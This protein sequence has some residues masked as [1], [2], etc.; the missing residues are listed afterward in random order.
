ME[1]VHVKHVK[2]SLSLLDRVP[3]FAI[4]NKGDGS[5]QYVR[6]HSQIENSILDVNPNPLIL[7]PKFYPPPSYPRRQCA[8][9]TKS[10]TLILLKKKM[11]TLIITAS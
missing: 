9:T 1:P 6:G 8:F 11:Y 7:N 10:E 3:L 2:E 5:L 4:P